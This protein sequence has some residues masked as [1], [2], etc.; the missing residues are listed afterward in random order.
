MLR[1]TYKANV[2]TS[3]FNKLTSIHFT[4]HNIFTSL[5]FLFDYCF[6]NTA[7]LTLLI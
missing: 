3:A 2:F 6:N 4:N 5:L 1:Y 7:D